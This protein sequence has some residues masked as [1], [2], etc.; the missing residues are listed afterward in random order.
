[1]CL[2]Y[3]ATSALYRRHVAPVSRSA[4]ALGEVPSPD[5]VGDMN[6]VLDRY[7]R[8]SSLPTLDKCSRSNEA[9]G[10]SAYMGVEAAK[11]VGEWLRSPEASGVKDGAGR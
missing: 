3:T 5:R 10:A 8:L 2:R 9:T 6:R 11:G 1:M 4:E 7:R